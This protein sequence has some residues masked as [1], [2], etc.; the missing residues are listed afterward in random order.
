MA[1][2]GEPESPLQLGGF[3]AVMLSESVDGVAYEFEGEG[4][5]TASEDEVEGFARGSFDL[6]AMKELDGRLLTTVFVCFLYWSRGRVVIGRILFYLES[7]ATMWLTVN[8]VYVWED[9]NSPMII[10]CAHFLTGGLL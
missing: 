9:Y 8:A 3:A 6:N 4:E 7:L 2:F 1:F 10:F 5:I